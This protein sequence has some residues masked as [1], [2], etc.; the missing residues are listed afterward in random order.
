MEEKNVKQPLGGAISTPHKERYDALD[1]LRALACV[2]IVL[3]HVKAN[4]AVQ[5]SEWFL[6]SN[7]ISFTGD[8]V[9]LFMMVSAFSVC[10]GYFMRFKNGSININDFYKKRYSRILPFFSVLVLLDI[11]KTIAEEHFAW[12]DALKAEL[13]ESFADV[14]LLFGLAPGNDIEVVGVG[15]FLGVIFVFYL[16]YPFFTTLLSNKK[17]AWCSLVVSFVWYYAL[18]CYFGPEKGVVIGKSTILGVM[19]YLLTGGLIYLYRDKV[20]VAQRLKWLK[21]AMLALTIGY[22]IWFFV[23]PDTRFEFANLIM[24]ALW[25][26]Y[27]ISEASSRRKWTLLNN[28]VMAFLSGISMEIYLCHMFIFRIVEKGHTEKFI[29]NN[30]LNYWVVCCLVLCGAVCFALAWK[31]IEKKLISK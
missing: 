28:K 17:L 29:A 24:Y 14:T 20:Q 1:G 25:T 11:V 30:D 8:F 12:T 22:T 15:W 6:T 26:I 13:W 16:L 23:C 7:V 2:G 19:P 18:A 3:M 10:C 4:I 31:K 27:A 21:W 5:P 9:L